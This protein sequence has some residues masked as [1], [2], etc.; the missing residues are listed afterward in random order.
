MW[1]GYR[2]WISECRYGKKNEN[3]MYVFTSPYA[4]EGGGVRRLQLAFA[5]SY[6]LRCLVEL[7]R[8][9]YMEIKQVTDT[10]EDK[11]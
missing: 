3:Y 7:E 6:I 9:G 10:Y 11:I 2:R 1:S 5:D 4:S 8:V